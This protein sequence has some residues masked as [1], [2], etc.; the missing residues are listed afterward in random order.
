MNMLMSVL[1]LKTIQLS[2]ERQVITKSINRI[3]SEHDKYYEVLTG[4][5]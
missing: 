2:V 3:I 5:E 1:P 4:V